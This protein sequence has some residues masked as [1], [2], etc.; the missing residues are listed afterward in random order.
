MS[1]SP[2]IFVLFSAKNKD[3]I[4]EPWLA[5]YTIFLEMASKISD[6]LLAIGYA[7]INLFYIF[8]DDPSQSDRVIAVL[9]N[10]SKFKVASVAIPS[11]IK[12]RLRT[13]EDNL[14][15][16]TPNRRY[17]DLSRELC[18]YAED[19]LP[20][21]LLS[22]AAQTKGLMIIPHGLLHL[23][24]WSTLVFNGKRLFEY[25]PVGILPNVS[26]VVIMKNK[27]SS[28]PK[29]GLIGPPD[30]DEL[31]RLGKLDGALLEIE[32]VHEIYSRSNALVEKPLICK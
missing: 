13:F 25:C 28:K 4:P 18:V 2:P 15:S 16:L 12:K 23:I 3:T 22:E 1:I 5:T 8:N 9:I 6:A 14:Q 29:V 24:P 31:P 10:S 17:Y 21:S 32:R 20:S 11:R 30:Y 26:C 27:S 7:A 19:L